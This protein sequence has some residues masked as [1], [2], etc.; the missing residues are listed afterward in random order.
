MKLAA[1]LLLTLCCI[2]ADGMG[3]SQHLRLIRPFYYNSG[4]PPARYLFFLVQPSFGIQSVI[5]SIDD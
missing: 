3:P 2:H 5:K 1:V 4:S